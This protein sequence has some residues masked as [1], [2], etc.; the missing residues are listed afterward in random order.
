[1][2]AKVV[3]AQYATIIG[4]PEAVMKFL[5]LAGGAAIVNL[6]YANIVVVDE[7]RAADMI[8]TAIRTTPQAPL[9]A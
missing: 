5:G 7:Q 2:A 8:A 6:D 4:T 9:H 1:M 3:N